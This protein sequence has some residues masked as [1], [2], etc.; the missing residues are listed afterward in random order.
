MHSLLSLDEATSHKKEKSLPPHITTPK[1]GPLLLQKLH[2]QVS[3]TPRNDLPKDKR[4]H[5]KYQPQVKILESGTGVNMSAQRATRRGFLTRY[6]V[7]VKPRPMDVIEE[8]L[9]KGEMTWSQLKYNVHLMMV[10]VKNNSILYGGEFL[11]GSI[12]MVG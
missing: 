6:P 2:R 9:T 1:R 11:R 7:V 10:S 8:H 4:Y 5:S 12:F 3:E